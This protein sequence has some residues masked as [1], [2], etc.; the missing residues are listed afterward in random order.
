MIHPP[1]T[2]APGPVVDPSA[3]IGPSVVIG[4]P[5]R[6]GPP[7]RLMSHVVIR[8]ATTLGARNVV[9]PGAVLGGEPQ[10]VAFRGGGS[11]FP[12]GGDNMFRERTQGHRGA[13]P[14]STPALGEGHYFLP[15]TEQ[16]P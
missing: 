15:E 16:C 14:G 3:E 6:I 4:G 12:I 7:T 2:T 5:A 11:F 13:L 8:G 10:D 1:G 9:H